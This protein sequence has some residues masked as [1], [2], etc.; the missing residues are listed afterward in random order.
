M[1]NVK[2]L[3]RFA[4][5]YGISRTFIK[6]LGRLRLNIPAILFIAPH[7][8]LTKKKDIA[9]IGCGQFSFST[10]AFF[11]I[12]NYGER[13]KLCCDI[14]ERNLQSFAAAYRVRNFILLKQSNIE[15]LDGINLAYI[16][17]NHASH[18]E[19]ALQ[20]LNQNID[21]YI[22][23]PIA[24]SFTQLS[25]LEE[26]SKT[27]TANIYCGYN[28]PFSKAIL[29]LKEKMTMAPFTM[30]CTVAGHLIASDHWYRNPSE[31]TRICG[32]LGHWI[33]LAIHLLGK[34][35]SFSFINIQINYADKNNPDDNIIIS[36]VTDCGD[37][38]SLILTAREEPF[39]GIN[40]TIFFQQKSLM[41][42]I[43]DFRT[44]EFQICSEKIIRKYKPKDVGHEKAILQPFS[45]LSRDINEV[46]LSTKIMLHI[47]D[48]VKSNAEHSI[49]R[50]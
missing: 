10:I 24:V 13:I 20:F 44:A 42:K 34:K 39:E 21:V 17:S 41:V 26:I 2:K 40:E 8:L 23:K 18:T 36:M 14:N 25:L 50:V 31:G 48:M 37:L 30:T 33:D 28:R 6:S 32:N 49:F 15:C 22:E 9:V 1:L 7:R 46:F 3:L 12:K 45:G 11:I 5:V 47:T 16:A 27:T 19:Y 38:I 43:D 29:E 35:G 4:S